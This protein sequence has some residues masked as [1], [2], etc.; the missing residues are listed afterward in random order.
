MISLM[1]VEMVKNMW[2]ETVW[3]FGV[4]ALPHDYS[5]DCF[6][7]VYHCTSN[8]PLQLLTHSLQLPFGKS[9]K[10]YL[11]CHLLLPVQ[12][13]ALDHTSI[14]P[15]PPHN[16]IVVFVTKFHQGTKLL[17]AQNFWL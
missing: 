5:F 11:D 2:D 12:M 3:T 14:D 13:H 15:P 8:W 1:L 16:Q 17:F 4:L 10:A 6:T 7:D 9:L